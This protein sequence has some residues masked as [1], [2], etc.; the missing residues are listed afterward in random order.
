MKEGKTTNRIARL[1]CIILC[2]S[3]IMVTLTGCY[4]N[5]EIEDLAYVVA[6]GIDEADNNMFN[7]TFQTAVPKSITTGEGETTD[8]KTF[9]TDNFISGFRKT[10]RYLSKKINLSH[11]K[12]IVVSE[13]IAK[14]GLLPFLNGLQNYM[15]LRPNVN[16]IVSAN[17][18]K[19]YIES[20]Q[21]KLSS[22]PTKFYDMMFKSYQ[23]DFRVPSSQ[24]GD[25]LYR[26]HSSGSQPVAIYTD[27]DNS[28]ID[29]KKPETDK[30][31]EEADKG[32]KNM[33]VKGLAVFNGD[34]MIGSLDSA[35]TSIYALMTGSIDNIKLEVRDPLDERYKI[36]S[37][38]S[39]D[40]SS[41]TSVQVY[42]NK[43][44]INID[45]NLHADVEA[46]QS[47]IN[48]SDPAKLQK[49]QKEYEDY[50]KNEMNSL[51]TKTSYECKSDIF[52]FG[53]IAKKN[54]MTIS[55]WDKVKWHE[56]FPNAIYRI[57]VSMTVSGQQ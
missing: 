8:I 22:S 32:K 26:T 1:F 9:K 31:E 53:Q 19:N 23:T 20:L 45:L 52:G 42:G 34:K 4:D 41:N 2:I 33:S 5:R 47:N 13:K 6:I 40:R 50:I 15:E 55:Q 43:P 18:A 44:E 38:V 29:S 11:T 25:Y 57:R 28:V 17:G 36:L 24:L 46:V 35:E 14:R 12:I 30:P 27:V 54:Y 3:V 7:L 10:G 48:Y 49:V 39:K 16:I 37:N 21:P 56:I 51:L